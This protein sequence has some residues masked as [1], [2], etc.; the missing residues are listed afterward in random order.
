MSEQHPGPNPEQRPQSAEKAGEII[1]VTHAHKEHHQEHHKSHERTPS[2]EQ[3]R[4]K[5]E[6]EAR[7]AEQT[8]VE[9]T[10]KDHDIA[11]QPVASTLKKDTWDRTMTRTQK[12]LSPPA[13]TLSKVIHNPVVDAVSTA[14]E[15]T[16]ARPAGIL[17][18]SITACVGSIFVLYMAKHYGF[19]YNLLLFFLLFCAGYL[20]ATLVEIIIASS[21][22]FRKLR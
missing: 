15:K 3:V 17:V 21:R 6:H 13:R 19:Q 22:R 8:P 14:G 5:V 10:H 4:S 18:G 11:Q 2:V 12:R 9:E 16:I 20:A 7:S 1:E